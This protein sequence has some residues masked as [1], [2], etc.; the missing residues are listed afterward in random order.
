MVPVITGAK[1]M[2]FGWLW[3][4][5]NEH[6][7]V[8]PKLVFVATARLGKGDFCWAI[9]FNLLTLACVAAFL[10]LT[11][12]KVRG[13]TSFLDAFIPLIM[14]HMGQGGLWWGFQFQFISAS[15]LACTLFAV[16]LWHGSRLPMS[17]AVIA[18]AC[19]FLLPL[20]GGNGLL[21]VPVLAT[22]LGLRGL[23]QWRIA[24]PSAPIGNE[25][26]AGVALVGAALSAGALLVLYRIGYVSIHYPWSNAGLFG[27]A[28][29]A[30]HVL[31]S[32]FGPLAERFWP[33]SGFLVIALVASSMIFM[34]GGVRRSVQDDPSSRWRALDVVA[35]LLATLTVVGGVGYGRGGRPWEPG[36]ASHYAGLALPV[37]LAVYLA[38][39]VKKRKLAILGQVGMLLFAALF[40]CLYVVSGVH[41]AKA[42]RRNMV[43]VRRDL[44]LGMPGKLVTDRHIANLFFVDS[45]EAKALVQSGIHQFRQAGFTLFGPPEHPVNS[46]DSRFP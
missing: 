30:D 34:V 9:Y 10:I 43:A 22:W 12:R 14:L 4:Q 8:L 13:R 17:A 44:L 32:G 37:L 28:L 19:L 16:L 46:R 45:P 21:F 35:F 15:A 7:I 24:G 36:L 27:T 20:C 29:T 38:L 6:R 3:A 26:G 5:H 25:R 40:S 23:R 18:G 33:W 1:P 41:R 2:T 31:M 11:A 42:E 39:C